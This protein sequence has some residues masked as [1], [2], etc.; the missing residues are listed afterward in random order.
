MR[1]HRIDERSYSVQVT[2][3][4]IEALFREAKRLG[5]DEG[6]APTNAEVVDLLVTQA[7]FAD[8]RLFFP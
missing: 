8:M 4:E 6:V 3:D 7:V 1:K 5:Y 2:P